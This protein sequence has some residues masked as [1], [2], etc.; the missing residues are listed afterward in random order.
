[1]NQSLNPYWNTRRHLPRVGSALLAVVF[2]FLPSSLFA[3]PQPATR[4]TVAT[5]LS[6]PTWVD[7]AT[8]AFEVV[9]VR[10]RGNKRTHHSVILRAAAIEPGARLTESDLAEV[11][12]RVMN[13]RL[14]SKVTA[15]REKTTRGD[16]LVIEV[17]ERWT[18]IP[19]PMVV[20]SGDGV[21]VGGVLFE[22]NLFGRN[23]QLALGGN[24][25]DR[26]SQFFAFYQDP[27]VFGTRFIGQL[28]ARYYTGPKKRY[29]S[30]TVIDAFEDRSATVSLLGGYRL[31]KHAS[32]LVGA[33]ADFGSTEV[34][35]DF[36]PPPERETIF[37]PQIRLRYD[38]QNYK[39]IANEGLRMEARYRHGLQ[40]P[41]DVAMLD[42]QSNLGRILP[43]NHSLSLSLGFHLRRGDHFLD[44]LILGGMAGTR[45]FHEQGLWVE[46]AA[47]STVEYAIPLFGALGGTWT[48]AAFVDGGVTEW[49][50]DTQTFITP[51]IGL[52]FFLKN[53]AIPAVGIDLSYSIDEGEVFPS[54]AIGLAM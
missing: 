42:I 4:A 37:G 43:W 8:N 17:A 29:E 10:S 52:G 47:L 54:A 15:R 30:E 3:Q 5:A 16:V 35:G 24:F 23:K 32:L 33:F 50:D 26:G 46:T 45:G 40:S 41:R 22:M 49:N 14:F 7:N 25:S 51:G 12:Q 53:V 11:R 36:M 9:A 2:A 38:G 44:A 1:M 13:L 20:G 39:I 21:T 18:L 27:A 6:E 48:F 28:S 19:L 34:Y 31:T